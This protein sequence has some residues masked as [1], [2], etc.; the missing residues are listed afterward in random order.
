MR[1]G[2]ALLIAGI[3]LLMGACNADMADMNACHL[4]AHR[5]CDKLASCDNVPTSDDC[6]TTVASKCQSF[7]NGSPDRSTLR[8]CADAL[9]DAVC[10]DRGIYLPA[11]CTDPTDLRAL[12]GPGGTSKGGGGG[13]DAGREDVRVDTGDAGG[14]TEDT[15][16]PRCP[17]TTPASGSACSPEG[18]VCHYTRACDASA[19]VATVDASCKSGRWS[20]A[21]STC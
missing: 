10:A 12:W 9:D 16:D 18:L 6:V 11:E 20:L 4:V 15:R 14:G 8:T 1:T 13:P 3:V 2:P 19:S 5:A 17:A 21:S 7:P